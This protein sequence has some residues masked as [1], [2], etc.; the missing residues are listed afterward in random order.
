MVNL[1][2]QR[3]GSLL[4]PF[5]DG[6][7]AP[8]RLMQALQVYLDLLLRWNARTNL[9]AIREPEEITTRHFGESLF[10]GVCVARRAG[11]AGNALDLG[12]GAGFP[13]IPMAL[14][15]PDWHLVL[16][17]SQGKKAAFLREAV[18]ALGLTAEVWSGRVETMPAD[19]L[20]DVVALRAVDR[21]SA[22]LELGRLRVAPGGL[23]LQLS[24]DLGENT[25]SVRIPGGAGRVLGITQR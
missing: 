20:F 18:R 25:E 8:P 9:T 7:A 1:S 22:M 21:M 23:L 14:L 6:M 5:L 17:E 16:A 24:G 2:E 13:G 11:S 10:S 12:S 3:I 19:R 15:L 4:D